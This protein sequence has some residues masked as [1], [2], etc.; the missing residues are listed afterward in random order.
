[1]VVWHATWSCACRVKCVVRSSDRIWFR[2]PGAFL[3]PR[4]PRGND[5]VVQQRA[6]WGRWTRYFPRDLW[7]PLPGNIST[8]EFAQRYRYA[9][10]MASL[11]RRLS[12]PFKT[13][14]TIVRIIRC[15]HPINNAIAQATRSIAS[16][17]YE[18][19]I[20]NQTLITVRLRW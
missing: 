1:M 18:T 11:L 8:T 19:R 16:R 20:R 7:P 9:A 6:R 3:P 13:S 15:A 2:L 17:S 5:D 12:A 14:A 4:R 10:T